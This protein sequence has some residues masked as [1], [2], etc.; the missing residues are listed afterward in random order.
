[1][2][3]PRSPA[4][5]SVR[6]RYA[7]A[8]PAPARSCRDLKERVG[9]YYELF[10]NSKAVEML[11]DPAVGRIIDANKAATAYYGW[12]RAE[13]REMRIGQINTL[14]PEAI[15][16][17]MRLA[18]AEKRSQFFFRHR[19]ASG[20]V[21]DVEVHSGPIFIEGRQLLYSIVHDITDR[22]RAETETRRLLS[23]QRALLDAAG[24]AIVATGPDGIITLFNPAAERMLGY[25]AADVVGRHTPA[26][27]HDPEEIAARAGALA[28]EG[29]QAD[30][31]AFRVLTA[32]AASGNGP[33]VAE[34]NCVRPDGTRLPVLV[35]VSVLADAEGRPA[36]FIGVAQDISSLKALEADLRRSNADLERFAY[37]AS[38]DLRQPLRMISGY[39]GLLTKA[40][41]SKLGPDEEKYIAFA[42]DGAKRMDQMIRDLLDYSRIGRTT[43]NFEETGLD[44]VL[45]RVLQTLAP[46][47]AETGA[48]VTVTPPLPRLL[49]NPFELERLFQN[50]IGNALKFRH[51]DRAPVIGVRAER[52]G[53]EWLIAVTD[54]GIGID[55][56]HYDRLFTIFQRLVTREQYEGNGIGL[57]T[58]RKIVEHHGGRIWIEAAPDVGSSFRVALPRRT[59][60]AQEEER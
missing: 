25:S 55:P 4:R 1:M 53:G 17:E 9:L 45:A 40:L 12:S 30:L 5:Y 39:L 49:G 47:I 18:D 38:H 15:A 57:A 32:K 42:I 50:L 11:V 16:E 3:S 44:E 21:R 26:L 60:L 58:C 41:K 8:G 14:S 10:E 35:S 46:A 56:A 27:F 28:A 31:S 20:E 59:E 13:L 6:T 37:V 52:R 23:F 24:N 54:N 34:W 33:D 36:G 48:A 2:P 7:A 29:N 19:L 22:R 43:G 51:P